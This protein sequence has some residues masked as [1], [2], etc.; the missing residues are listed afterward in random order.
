MR[1]DQVLAKRGDCGAP[2][3][4]V[5]RDSRRSSAR[6]HAIWPRSTIHTSCTLYIVLYYVQPDSWLFSACVI[7]TV[8][9]FLQCNWL[10]YWNAL[11]LALYC[12]T[13]VVV[14]V[15]PSLAAVILQQY[16]NTMQL[17]LHTVYSISIAIISQF[18]VYQSDTYQ[19]TITQWNKNSFQ[20]LTIRN[21]QCTARSVPCNHK[22]NCIQGMSYVNLIDHHTDADPQSNGFDRLR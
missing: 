5:Y 10:I 20:Y 14:S 1:T 22:Y 16:N 21:L 7:L 18:N 3:F 11:K 6:H 8:H 9:L 4:R 12:I 17:Y 19:D 13:T 2:A 15:V